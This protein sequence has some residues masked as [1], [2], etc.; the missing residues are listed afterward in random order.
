MSFAETATPQTGFVAD[1]ARQGTL[2]QSFF[3]TIGDIFG[4][5]D[6]SNRV[7]VLG[8]SSTDVAV[9][10]TGTPYIRGTSQG[11]PVYGSM[12]TPNPGTTPTPDNTGLLLLMGAA[13]LF[14]FLRKGK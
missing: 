5:S 6:V 13:F 4:G 11:L 7:P 14:V 9:D 2:T 1:A 8:P 3:Y 10:A 12:V